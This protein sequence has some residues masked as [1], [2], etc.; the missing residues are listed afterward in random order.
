MRG[1]KRRKREIR[2]AGKEAE[3]RMKRDR[4]RNEDRI[5]RREEM[6]ERQGRKRK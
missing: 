3:R 5:K 4:R 6:K 2:S 1:D